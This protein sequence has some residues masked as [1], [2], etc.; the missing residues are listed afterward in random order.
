MTHSLLEGDPRSAFLAWLACIS[1]SRPYCDAEGGWLGMCAGAATEARDADRRSRRQRERTHGLR[2][3][4]NQM[5]RNSTSADGSEPGPMPEGAYQ[6]PPVPR[7]L[8]YCPD[9]SGCGQVQMSSANIRA[10]ICLD[11]ASYH[12]GGSRG[13]D[14]GCTYVG[15]LCRAA[16]MQCWRISGCS[17]VLW[18]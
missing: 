17:S 14:G 3:M 1:H 15:R 2:A 4:W 8:L 5:W 13:A 10:V 9:S 6:V 18:L 16:Q 12:G 7:S 11:S